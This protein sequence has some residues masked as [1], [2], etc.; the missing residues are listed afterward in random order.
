[1]DMNGANL[2]IC[3]YNI[4]VEVLP[5]CIALAKVSSGIFASFKCH[6]FHFSGHKVYKRYYV[7]FVLKPLPFSNHNA[8]LTFLTVPFLTLFRMEEGGRGVK[9]EVML[10]SLTKM[11]E[12][13]N[14]GHVTTFTL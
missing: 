1:M 9:I 10:T 2:F 14:F 11:L 12:L 3:Y 5:K 7:A 13:P 6:E 4:S 8:L